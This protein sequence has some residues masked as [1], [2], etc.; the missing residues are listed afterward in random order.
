M[1]PPT[2]HSSTDD[3][4]HAFDPHAG[5]EPLAPAARRAMRL[6]AV[7]GGLALAVAIAVPSSLLMVFR[8]EMQ[9]GTWLG[10]LA[11]LALLLAGTAWLLAGARWRRT[12]WRL[13]HDGL[14]IRRGLIWRS[15]TLVPRSR[16][17]H[18]DLGHGPLDR[19]FGLAG[20]KI[21][22]AGTRLAAVTLEGLERARAEALRDAL[23]VQDEDHADASAI[24]GVAPD[25]GMLR[26]D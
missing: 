22:T 15:E 8:G 1:H 10:L 4:A 21:Y 5:F 12:H 16:V 9:A 23:V 3:D 14:T 13:D 24:A 19:H 18:V 6:S 20:L 25:Q 11:G 7:L 2:T 26:D 17:Q